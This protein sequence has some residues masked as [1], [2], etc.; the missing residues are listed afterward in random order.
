MW[1]CCILAFLSQWSPSLLKEST[2][3]EWMVLQ[4]QNT[5]I[6]WLQQQLE[7]GQILSKQPVPSAASFDAQK[8]ESKL[9]QDISEKS[10]HQN[11]THI[12][13]GRRGSM[14]TAV[15][16]LR[17][18]MKL[19]LLQCLILTFARSMT[20]LWATTSAKRRL[21]GIDA[22]T[23]DNTTLNVLISSINHKCP[24]LEPGCSG[25]LKLVCNINE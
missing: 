7:K 10:T 1:S 9:Q 3:N 12:H 16:S 11:V 21:H 13:T 14:T 5:C 18:L 24:Q 15:F 22:V 4:Q 2:T 19:S 20:R 6:H 25:E 23:K 8:Y 17:S